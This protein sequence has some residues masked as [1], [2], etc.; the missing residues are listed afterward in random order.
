MVPSFGKEGSSDI[1]SRV[2]EEDYARTLAGRGFESRDHSHS[3]SRKVT[4]LK[5]TLPLVAVVLIVLILVWPHLKAT[6]NAFKIGF[7]SV[8]M[9]EDEDP[10]MHNARYFGADENKQPYSITAD[11]ATAL[12][13]GAQ[14]VE[15]EMPKA[16]ISLEDGTWLVLT[17]KNGIY[18]RD[19]EKMN[20]SG[21]VNLFHDT[22][23]EFH[24]EKAQINLR[25]GTASG[26]VPIEGQGP[27]G[28]LKA[29]GFKL[30]DKGSRILFLGKSK[31]ILYPGVAGATDQ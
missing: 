14:A 10:S 27:F 3:Y 18:K 19:V 6:D 4:I 7:S 25:A 31:L 2:S 8:K 12:S 30:Y 9:A 17:A 1:K 23:Y 15:L 11:L 13:N 5:L 26:N 29:E 16:D 28:N 22:G 21:A 20:L 24:T